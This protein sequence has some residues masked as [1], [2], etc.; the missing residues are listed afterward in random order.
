MQSISGTVD[1]SGFAGIGRFDGCSSTGCLLLQFRATAP[2]RV[3]LTIGAGGR[4]LETLTFDV[5][6]R[7]VLAVLA[8][9]VTVQAQ[10]AG[11]SATVSVSAGP[12]ASWAPTT[13]HYNV[14][15][16]AGTYDSSSTPSLA[17]PDGAAGV[18]VV[19][20]T[21]SGDDF[22]VTLKDGATTSALYSRAD[23]P[24]AGIPLGKASRM[25][26]TCAG[27]V[28]VVYLIRG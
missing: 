8:T 6:G 21:G 14:L 2:V 15:L 1:S 4:Y 17:P 22:T 26:L 10:A 13:L 9:E 19:P 25:L 24:T 7:E 3:Q 28:R 5:V 12:V 27:A 11:G 16:D 20:R 23:Q 18:L